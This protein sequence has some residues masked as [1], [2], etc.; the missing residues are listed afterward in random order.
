[1]C[2]EHAPTIAG[3]SGAHAYGKPR[4]LV[5]CHRQINERVSNRVSSLLAV[6]SQSPSLQSSLSL[7][8]SPPQLSCLKGRIVP[9]LLLSCGLL[10]HLPGRTCGGYGD[11]R[12]SGGQGRAIGG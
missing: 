2:T 12:R 5:V 1:M 6:E 4:G 3:L 9:H 10:S 11:W 8:G 7:R